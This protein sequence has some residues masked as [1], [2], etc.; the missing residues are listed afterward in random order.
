[1]SVELLRETWSTITSSSVAIVVMEDYLAGWLKV[2]KCSTSAFRCNSTYVVEALKK[3]DRYYYVAQETHR[4]VTN[5][6]PI[7]D[8]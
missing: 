7:A 3:K 6:Y 5:I 2:C 8:I 1:M 4:N